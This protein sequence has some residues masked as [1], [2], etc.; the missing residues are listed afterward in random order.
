MHNNTAPRIPRDRFS[1][2]MALAVQLGVALAGWALV[3][4]IWEGAVRL[5]GR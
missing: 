5:A 2:G 3:Y 1:A 4:L